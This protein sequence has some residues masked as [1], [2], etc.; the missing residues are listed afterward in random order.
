MVL[1][2][3]QQELIIFLELYNFEPEAVL[4]MRA[5]S[6]FAASHLLQLSG[7]RRSGVVYKENTTTV[8]DPSI[9]STV[10]CDVSAVAAVSG[11]KEPCNGNG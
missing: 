6:D 4:V 3:S 8:L 7:C 5:Y 11:S 10:S 9:C 2:N 1:K